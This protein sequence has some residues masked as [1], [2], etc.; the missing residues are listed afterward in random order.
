MG[1]FAAD[2]SIDRKS[3][4]ESEPRTLNFHQIQ[5]AREAALDVMNSKSIDEALIIFTEGLEPVREIG[6]EK[7]NVIPAGPGGGYLCHELRVESAGPIC[8]DLRDVASAPF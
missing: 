8:M 3:S 2:N 5:S 7:R 1:S 6:R 4:I